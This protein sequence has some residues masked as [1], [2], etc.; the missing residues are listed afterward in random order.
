[1]DEEPDNIIYLSAAEIQRER[2]LVRRYCQYY[3]LIP[4]GNNIIPFPTPSA[5]DQTNGRI[6]RNVTINE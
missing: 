6:T 5:F 2:D 1:M 4:C 3:G